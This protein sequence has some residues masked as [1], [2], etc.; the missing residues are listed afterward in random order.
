MSRSIGLMGMVIV[1]AI[2]GYLYLNQTQGLTSE[3]VTPATTI[4]LTGVRLDLLAIANAE[5]R[6]WITNSKY[7]SLDE[8]R[9]DGDAGVTTNGRGNFIYSSEVGDTGFKI[10]ATYSGPEANAPRRISVNETMAV[11]IE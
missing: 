11:K 6:Y 7:A 10:V 9:K 2:G 8:L 5:R 1:A 4:D 3:G